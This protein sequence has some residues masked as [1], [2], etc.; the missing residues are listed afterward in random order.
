MA[1][2]R[3]PWPRIAF[4]VIL[5]ALLLFFW[6]SPL[7]WPVKIVVVL[8]HELGHA[9]AAWATGGSVEAIGL[10]PAEGGHAITRGGSRLI[11]LNAGYLG[12][13][14]AGV[15]LLSATRSKRAVRVVTWGLAAVLLVVAVL[16]V[17]PL[18]SFGFAFTLVAAGVFALLGRYGSTD[19]DRLIL[20]ALG[21]F[22]VLYAA[23][24]IRSDV[25]QGAGRSDAHMLAELTWI[26]AAVWGLAWL[27][28]G[29]A[30]L[31][32]MRKR[33]V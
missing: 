12:S 11:V 27:A 30:V 24:D 7:L 20:R 1:E 29:I 13:M 33:L 26:P 25:F 14:L 23:F 4:L 6:N 32:V 19:L 28:L 8:F 17:R 31:W 3:P 22:S 2:A 18:L 5:G 15:G 9:V 10:S 16:F 21:L